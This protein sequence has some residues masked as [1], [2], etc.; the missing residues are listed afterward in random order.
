MG[1]ASDSIG[2]T[3]TWLDP[4][5]LQSMNFFSMAFQFD[6]TPCYVARSSFQ[7]REDGRVQNSQTRDRVTN[8]P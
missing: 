3:R 8:I 2:L 6:V 5:K 7:Q 1:L 4:D